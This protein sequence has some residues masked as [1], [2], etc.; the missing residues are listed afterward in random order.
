MRNMLVVHI[1]NMKYE[2]QVCKC[3]LISK[4]LFQGILNS[5]KKNLGY[6]A[7]YNVWSNFFGFLLV[8]LEE[9][10]TPKSPFEI[11]SHL[12]KNKL[13]GAF[14]AFPALNKK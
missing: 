8:F 7:V 10:K 3:Q 6:H 13:F 12:L 11:N 5:S 14:P 2:K 1:K 4:G 9:L